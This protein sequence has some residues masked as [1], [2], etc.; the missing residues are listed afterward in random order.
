ME[1]LSTRLKSITSLRMTPSVAAAAEATI[2][3]V[4]AVMNDPATLSTIST[5]IQ[6]EAST[7]TTSAAGILK[8]ASISNHKQGTSVTIKGVFEVEVSP[9]VSQVRCH[10]ASHPRLH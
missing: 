3:K 5:S 2:I 9:R 6:N 8:S 1:L 7:S 4:N 10:L